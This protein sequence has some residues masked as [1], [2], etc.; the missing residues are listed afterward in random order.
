MIFWMHLLQR[1]FLQGRHCNVEEEHGLPPTPQVCGGKVYDTPQ[2]RPAHARLGTHP[3][4]I[5]KDETLEHGASVWQC[6][7]IFP[8]GPGGGD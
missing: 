5:E 2:R 4:V 6:I 3:Y 8:S 1:V 7:N